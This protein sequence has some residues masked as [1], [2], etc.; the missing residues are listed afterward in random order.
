VYART[1]TPDG[2]FH[3]P[4]GDPRK[5]CE[6]VSPGSKAAECKGPAALAKLARGTGETKGPLTLSH[7]TTNIVIEASPA[8]AR[9]KAYLSLP[10]I[11]AEGGGMRVAGLYEDTL[12]KTA[13]GWKFKL[14]MYTPIPNPRQGAA[15]PERGA[16]AAPGREAR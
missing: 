16:P 13:D 1:F 4:N 15:A 11:G 6:P 3:F 10:G 8:G 5:R 9:G 12:V 2:A 7:V 14:R